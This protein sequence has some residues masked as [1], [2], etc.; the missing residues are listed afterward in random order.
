MNCQQAIFFLKPIIYVI[1]KPNREYIYQSFCNA[2]AD[3][4]H[5]I[6][7]VE[8]RNIPLSGNDIFPEHKEYEKRN[9]KSKKI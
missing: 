1:K 2:D 3:I 9:G 6:V 5:G 7:Q 4:G 8:V